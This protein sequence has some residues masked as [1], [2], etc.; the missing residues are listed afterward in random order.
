MSKTNIEIA[1]QEFFGNN[2]INRSSAKVNF[3][4]RTTSFPIPKKTISEDFVSIVKKRIQQ[5]KQYDNIVLMWSGGIDST[6]V[7]YALID[8]NIDFEIATSKE[9]Y[10]EYQKLYEQIING[11]FLNVKKVTMLNTVD[12]DFFNGKTIVTGEIGDQLCGSMKMLEYKIFELNKPAEMFIPKIIYDSYK[13]PIIELVGDNPT[14]SEFLWGMNFVYKYFNV[15]IRLRDILKQQ[16][17]SGFSICHFFNT[18]E[19]QNWSLNNYKSNCSYNV[20][21]DYKLVFK[22]YIYSKNNDLNYKENKLKV[23]S[24]SVAMFH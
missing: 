22:E 21:T 15:V 19:F 7:F 8:A 20:E 13:E 12:K 17:F 5:L 24:L 14:L 18:V 2:P 11:E 1:F 23:P 3:V 9:A 4:S 16:G 10:N 6:L